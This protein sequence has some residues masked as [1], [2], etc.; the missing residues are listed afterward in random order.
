MPDDFS[1]PDDSLDARLGPI[2]DEFTERLKCGQR[3]TDE[4]YTRRYPDLAGILPE[5]FDT[6]RRI[7]PPALVTEPPHEELVSACVGDYRILRRINSGGMGEVYEA[8][9]CSL[10]RRVAL[11]VLPFAATLNAHQLQRF[12]REAE[13]AAQLHHTN[14][15]PVYAVGCDRGIHYY[16]MQYI[17]GQN[18]AEVIQGLRHL[19]R[20]ATA[21]PDSTAEPRSQLASELASGRWEAAD[22]GP[23]DGDPTGPYMPAPLRSPTGAAE[24]ATPV[25]GKRKTARPTQQAAF[26]QT[27]ARLGIKAAEALEYAHQMGVIHRDIK[28]ANLLL[29]GR[30]N[31]WITDFGLAHHKDHA[32]LSETGVPLGTLRY[33][34]PEQA[35]A[36]RGWVDPRTDVYS[37]GA[38]LYEVLTLA[39]VFEGGDRDELLVQI[40]HEE[41]QPPQRLNPALPA[42]LETIVLKALNK[43]VGSRYAT[44]QEMADDLRR[45]LEDKPIL[46]KR[47]TLGERL[48]K[49][50]RRHKNLVAAA[51]VMF[52]VILV[53]LVVS[54]VLIWVALEKRNA[55]LQEAQKVEDSAGQAIDDAYTKVLSDLLENLPG[56]AKLQLEFLEKALRF[57]GQLSQ[58][59]STGLK[60]RRERGRAYHRIGNIQWKL[61]EFDR[62]KDA[63]NQAIDTL[64]QLQREF[65]TD[66][67]CQD[68]LARTH[69]SM[70][71]FQFELED[72]PN[73][74]QAHRE[75]VKQY[76]LLVQNAPE[77][78][79]YKEEH[80][81]SYFYLVVALEKVP[82]AREAK[83]TYEQAIRIYQ[84]LLSEQLPALP[85]IG[86]GVVALGAPLLRTTPFPVV[87]ALLTGRAELSRDVDLDCLAESYERLGYLHEK[88]QRYPEAQDAYREAIGWRRERIR[89]SSV[90]TLKDRQ[91][92]GISYHNLGAMLRDANQFPEAEQAFRLALPFWERLAEDFPTQASFWYELGRTQYFLAYA[93]RGQKKNRDDALKG[94]KEKLAEACT[95]LEQAIRSQQTAQNFNYRSRDCLQ[96]LRNS[97]RDLVYML[98]G[99][100]GDHAK[101]AR[102]TAE[103]SR[104]PLPGP[105]HWGYSFD[106]ATFLSRCLGLA[107]KDP[108]LTAGQRDELLEIY[109]R[110]ALYWLKQALEKGRGDGTFLKMLK[111]EPHLQPLRERADFLEFLRR[112]E[113]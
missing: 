24:R 38:T 28:P 87:A 12:Q 37:L 59:R 98:L 76:E 75:A 5:K 64:T 67:D 109:A 17:D 95:L 78:R 11:K 79:A 15:V 41:P 1:L 72:F 44:A 94:R 101:A 50:T 33:M 99:G 81:T 112:A 74:V 46:A 90:V 58:K 3:P 53:V 19:S 92:L 22:G 66:L 6:L 96:I 29:D 80:A 16:A 105:D 45:F 49:W 9:Q 32:G 48:G 63:Y 111:E 73:A 89:R 107:Q 85:A 7:V 100:I 2:M 40:A 88:V 51:G 47:P 113:G 30:G 68:G 91:R 23:P 34:S 69:N 36:K 108:E 84:E 83:E 60:A 54:T 39:P 97:H 42:D 86:A 25:A 21:S 103:L 65:P 93:L 18:V 110:D 26:F 14:I 31:L 70:G 43:D 104:L 62:A 77:V 55:A 106:Y 52:G 27:V 71:R 4:E 10:K 35:R 8:E 82:R 57:Y 13:M 61:G 56:R 20:L 102:V